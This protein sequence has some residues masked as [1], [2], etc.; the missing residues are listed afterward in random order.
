MRKVID[1]DS[2]EFTETEIS[3]I[4][5]QINMRLHPAHRTGLT[6]GVEGKSVTKEEITAL[7]EAIMQ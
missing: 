7:L 3:E 4:V 2:L 5:D 1:T 6:L